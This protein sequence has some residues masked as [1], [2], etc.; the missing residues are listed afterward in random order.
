[1]ASA[2]AMLCGE[3][4]RLPDCSLRSLPYRSTAK[5]LPS[6]AAVVAAG[7]GG[8][9]AAPCADRPAAQRVAAR[10]IRSSIVILFFDVA[11][12][13]PFASRPLPGTT[14]Q[15]DLGPTAHRRYRLGDGHGGGLRH[16]GGRQAG[17]Q[18]PLA[19]PAPGAFGRRPATT[20]R[21][22]SSGPS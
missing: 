21:C 15:P 14:L 2:V 20:M 17:A 1:M 3:R 4:K 19:P 6:R 12:R 7:L 22:T 16:A 9:A 11:P 8:A 10:A 18:S 13:R 5:A